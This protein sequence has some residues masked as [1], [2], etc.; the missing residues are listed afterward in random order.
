MPETGGASGTGGEQTATHQIQRLKLSRRAHR[1]QMTKLINKASEITGQ[2]HDEITEEGANTLIST[3]ENISKK[4]AHLNKLDADIMAA[5]DVAELENEIGE[6]DDYD[7]RITDRLVSFRRFSEKLGKRL[8]P[9]AVATPTLPSTKKNVN[10][11]KLTLEKFEGDI[12]KW[13]SFYDG[14]KAAVHDDANLSNIQRFQYL[15]AHLTGEAAKSID[16]LSLSNSNYTQAMELLTNRYGQPHK[17]I[18][19][20]MRALWDLERPTMNVQSL[21]SFYDKLESYIRGLKALGKAEDSYGELLVPLILDKIPTSTRQ[22]ITRVYGSNEWNL[23]ELREAL[24]K[25]IEV[26]QSGNNSENSFEQFDGFSSEP[27]E[28]SNLLVQGGKPKPRP[29]NCVFCKTVSHAP[30][31]CQIVADPAKRLQVVKR[32]NLCFNCLG[33]HKVS[34]CKSKYRCKKCDTAC[35]FL[36]GC[37][38]N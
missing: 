34:A 27:K 5:M 29:R 9:I 17:V 4:Q 12:L 23:S 19:A 8:E 25:E 1:G 38:P 28:H 2:G 16:G 26:L 10:L 3:I 22:Q 11:P 24:R 6:T 35:S 15:K 20:Y 14:F 37:R 32:D 21:R 30:T 18:S 13:Q 7:A 36:A 33:R 31:E